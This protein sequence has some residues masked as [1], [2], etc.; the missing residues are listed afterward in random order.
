MYSR[1]ALYFAALLAVSV[2]ACEKSGAGAATTDPAKVVGHVAESDLVTV[3]L[4]PEAE[5]RLGIAIAKVERRAVPQTRTLGGEVIAPASAGGVARYAAGN[6]DASQLAGAQIDADAAASKAAAARDVAK[7]RYDRVEALVKAQAESQKTLDQARA[8]LTSAEAD[9]QAAGS[10]RALLGQSVTGGRAPP[11]VWIRAAVFSADAARLDLSAPAQVSALAGGAA[12]AVKPAAK[13][14]TANP[15]ASTVNVF[16]EGANGDG[17]LRVGERV[18][19][20]VPTRESAEGLVVPYAAILYD[21]NGGE[22]IYVRK[23]DHVYTRQ[24]VAVR[25]IV[26]GAAMIAAGPPVG[27]EIVTTGAPELFGTEF[28]VAH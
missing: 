7:A 14:S 23:A 10:R 26:G 11:R 5:K 9:V 12:R 8:D 4:T 21:V 17:A 24:R 19:L 1:T 20:I 27:T 18:N 3:T 28:G 15:Q 13:P 2:C 22:W 6:L 16:Y 25:A